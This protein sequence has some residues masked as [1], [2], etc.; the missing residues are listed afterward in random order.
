[1]SPSLLFLSLLLAFNAAL[2]SVSGDDPA[3]AL[4]ET[5]SSD[6][7]PADTS[8]SSSGQDGVPQLTLGSKIS[9]DGLGPTI[10]GEDGTLRRITNWDSLSQAEKEVASRRIAKRNQVRTFASRP[11]QTHIHFCLPHELRCRRCPRSTKTA[12]VS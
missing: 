10:I 2:T 8:D 12:H 7:Q 6:H 1:M 9:L 3:L 11:R 5:S 4:P